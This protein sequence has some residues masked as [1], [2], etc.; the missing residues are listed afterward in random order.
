MALLNK[1][2]NKERTPRH[3]QSEAVRQPHVA[4]GQDAYAFRRSRTLTGSI[5][6]EVKA[7]TESAAQLKSPR[8][9]EHELRAKRRKLLFLLIAIIAAM[10]IIY[11]LLTQF[12]ARVVI[13]G[14]APHPQVTV[15]ATLAA[16]Y[17][18][19]IQQYLRERPFERFAFA[20][21]QERLTTYVQQKY[22]EVSTVTLKNDMAI[23]SSGFLIGLR[24][25]VVG[26]RIEPKQLYV[27]S[28]GVSFERNL[29]AD[30][31]V[32]IK[33]ETGLTFES[34]G[35]AVASQRFLSFVGRVV[36]L[37]N[38]SGIGQ[39]TQVIMPANTTR[40]VIIG[41]EGQ[42]YTFK[43]HIDR[44]PATQVEDARLALAHMKQQGVT[45]QYIDVR[46]AG[47][48]FYR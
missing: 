34:A 1:K 32:K 27:D 45:P 5:S 47:K 43:L 42:G 11:W 22:P 21:H 12:T 44:D 4:N 14:Y 35:S 3:R 2:N 37:T 6:S 15:P 46:T 28:N 19:S 39:V 23:G 8:L 48:A 38:D 16:E 31:T 13:T 9:K 18:A 36:A 25:P 33:D 7:A 26:W 20:L 29:Y 17:E 30:P 10:A 40:T 41:L 24:T